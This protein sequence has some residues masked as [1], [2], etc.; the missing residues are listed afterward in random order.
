MKATLSSLCS[1]ATNR[2]I[3]VKLLYSSIFS[4]QGKYWLRRRMQS[5]PGVRWR[6][7]AQSTRSAQVKFLL[8]FN[9]LQL[10]KPR[11]FRFSAFL[12]SYTLFLSSFETITIYFQEYFDNLI[13][14]RPAHG[15]KVRQNTHLGKGTLSLILSVSLSSQSSSHLMSFVLYPFISSEKER[16]FCLYKANI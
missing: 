9:R 10:S 11:Q 14:T 15:I 2:I 3:T 5:K 7:Y 4:S 16:S 8:F 6:V 1:C 12:F 13:S